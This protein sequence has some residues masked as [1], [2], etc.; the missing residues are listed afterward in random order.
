MDATV[1]HI[2]TA[3]L[4]LALNA[5]VYALG[6]LS[7]GLHLIGCFAGCTG[8]RNKKTLSRVRCL[9]AGI[10]LGTLF[11]GLMP[12]VRSAVQV[13]LLDA[14][15][16]DEGTA[17]TSFPVAEAMVF[18][19]FCAT[20]YLESLLMAMGRRNAAASHC[21]PTQAQQQ[22]GSP[23][24]SDTDLIDSPKNS[25][26][27]LLTRGAMQ[28][29]HPAVTMTSSSQH[30][31]VAVPSSYDLVEDGQDS[32]RPTSAAGYRLA[33]LVGAMAVHSVLDGLT[34]GLQDKTWNVA[35]MVMGV[36]LHES[37]MAMAMGLNAASAGQSTA[38]VV[39]AGIVVAAAVPFG[40][41][42]GLIMG[43]QIGVVAKAV[44]QALAAGTFFH[45]TFMEVLPQELSRQQ[46]HIIKVTYMIV[47]FVLLAT[48]NVTLS[49]LSLAQG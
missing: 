27:K 6:Y 1:L 23:G 30:D 7:A 32:E 14:P 10:F 39:K 43:S 34:L 28:G 37:L 5:T 31:I 33:M 47:G 3:M 38:S 22:Q 46:D 40:Q 8:V 20:L 4:G 24:S 48:A 41:M 36:Y 44:V 2:I 29:Q 19:G 16:G 12:A 49:H 25:W 13:A 26:T 17:P 18:V 21:T 42:T 35:C 45:V 11:L 9:A 15:F